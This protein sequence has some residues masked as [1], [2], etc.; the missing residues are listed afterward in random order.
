[1]ATEVE[2]LPCPW[3]GGQPSLTMTDREDV[4]NTRVNISLLCDCGVR[5]PAVRTSSVF[6]EKE[7]M[8][9]AIIGWNTRGC[10]SEQAWQIKSDNARPD[11]DVIGKRL[12]K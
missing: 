4:S 7:Q 5:G 12:S 11:R 6:P 9:D 2:P 10:A 3:C 1:M 8:I